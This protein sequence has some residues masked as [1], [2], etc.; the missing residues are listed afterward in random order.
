MELK[1]Q[2]NSTFLAQVRVSRRIHDRQI[3]L[4][5][6]TF[7][8]PKPRPSQQFRSNRKS[9]NTSQQWAGTPSKNQKILKRSVRKTNER[10]QGS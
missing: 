8:R 2:H 7:E 3:K 9:L 5:E 6:A 4:A 1:D 10:S